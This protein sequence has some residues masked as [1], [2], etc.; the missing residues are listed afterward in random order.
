MLKLSTDIRYLKGIGEKRAELFNKLGV[1]NIGDLI[2]FLPRA[3][4]DRTDVR[5]ICDIEEGESVC[6]RASL[7]GGVRS[8][9]ARTGSKVV[10]TR[11]S[12]GTGILN[13]TWFNAPYVVNA[14]S[15]GEYFTFFGKVSRKGM[16][17]EMINP[18]I[19]PETKLGEKTGKIIPVYPCTKGLTQQNIRGAVESALKNLEEPV[20]DIIPDYIREKYSLQDAYRAIRM[21]HFPGEFNAFEEAHRTLAFEEF[22]VLQTGVASSK[23]YRSG[24]IAPRISNVKCIVISELS[25]I[26]ME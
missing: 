24:K 11:V 18:I 23:R 7:A 16:I 6:V 8:F 4:E 15:K 26:V 9:R 22:L 21:M 20:A 1:F 19:E 14:L 12:D 17:F 3:Y 2:R 10:Q 5:E 25:P 13:L